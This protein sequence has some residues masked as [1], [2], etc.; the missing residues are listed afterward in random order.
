[1]AKKEN[2][3]AQAAPKDK[4]GAPKGEKVDPDFKYIVRIANSDLDGNRKVVLALTGIKGV[5]SRMAHSIARL[6]GVPM[7]EKIGN[8]KDEQ[9]DVIKKTLENISETVPYWM[10]NRQNDWESGVDRHILGTEVAIQVKDD[11][12]LMKKMRCYKGV[13]HDL[14]HKVR[15]QKTKSNGRKGITLGVQR[16][17]EKPATAEGG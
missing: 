17:T 8:L 3:T 14:G 16:K 15:G 6:S 7:L 10:L 5:G 13:K 9:I 12:N 1:M 11:I 2:P 4:Q